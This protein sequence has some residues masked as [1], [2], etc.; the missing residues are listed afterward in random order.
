MAIS[1]AFLSQIFIFGINLSQFVSSYSFSNNII[2]IN[3]GELYGG[4]TK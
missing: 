3:P 1:H 2:F 4:D